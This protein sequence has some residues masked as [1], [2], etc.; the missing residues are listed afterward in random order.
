MTCLI[1]NRVSINT[2]YIVIGFMLFAGSR[3]ARGI[4]ADIAQMQTAAER[5]SISQEIK[6][7][8]AYFVGRGVEQ[9]ST[10]AAYWYEKAANAGDPRA[11]KQIGFFYQAGI[12]VPRDPERAVRWFERAAAGGLVDAKVNLGVAYLKGI[13]VRKDPAFAAQL[14]REAL[15]QGD[16]RAGFSLGEMYFF[17]DGVAADPVAARHWYEQGVKQHEPLAEFRLGILLMGNNN[18][19]PHE[20]KKAAELLRASSASGY[21]PAMHMLGVLVLRHPELAR[22]TNE[23]VPLLM[24]AAAAGIWQSSTLLGIL[25]RDG[26]EMPSDPAAAYYHFR[27]A[28]LQGGDQA[29]QLLANDL[30][31]L[32]ARLGPEKIKAQ[33]AEAAAWFQKHQVALEF[34]Y[35]KGDERPDFPAY[36]LTMPGDDRTIGLL[37]GTSPF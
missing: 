14:F 16:G 12:G 33:D 35:R 24:D 34:I 28:T 23:A 10:L 4:D 7:G 32:A 2:T 1:H 30:R 8:A 20:L 17:G 31:L 21:V 37:L 5:G 27:V 18:P 3:S 26:M 13:G 19:R 6:L 25:A 36:A 15:A 9:N 29:A 22:S 11:Q